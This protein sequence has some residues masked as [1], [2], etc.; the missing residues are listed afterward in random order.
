MLR[1]DANTHPHMTQ[2]KV[3]SLIKKYRPPAPNGREGKDRKKKEEP[4]EAD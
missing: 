1:V 2:A 3:P 4:V